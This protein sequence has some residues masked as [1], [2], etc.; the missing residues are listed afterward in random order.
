MVRLDLEPGRIWRPG[1]PP[2]SDR[3]T[4]NSHLLGGQKKKNILSIPSPS[5]TGCRGTLVPAWCLVGGPRVAR[6]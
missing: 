3:L 2:R 5:E 6:W 4:V 1:L